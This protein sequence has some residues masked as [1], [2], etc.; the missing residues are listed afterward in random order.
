MCYT[1]N[2]IAIHNTHRLPVEKRIRTR[3]LYTYRPGFTSQQERVDLHTFD[4]LPIKQIL[5][6]MKEITAFYTIH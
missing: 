6:M 5:I 2:I 4:N 1:E 3:T